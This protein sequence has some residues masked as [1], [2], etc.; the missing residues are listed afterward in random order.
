M[1]GNDDQGVDTGWRKEKRG[2]KNQIKT[3]VRRVG[4]KDLPVPEYW[5][6]TP[7]WNISK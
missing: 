1:H 2:K 4:T 6:R 7:D 5:N 3:W